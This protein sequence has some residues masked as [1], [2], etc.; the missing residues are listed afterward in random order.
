MS[1]MEPARENGAEGTAEDLDEVVAVPPDP[2][3]RPD[4]ERPDA[5]EVITLGYN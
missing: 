4:A 3:P 1:D 5:D 2:Q